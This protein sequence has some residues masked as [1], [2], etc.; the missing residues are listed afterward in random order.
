[1][2]LFLA[3]ELSDEVR[4]CFVQ[5]QKILAPADP[6]FRVA[7]TRPENLHVTV[8]FLGEVPDDEVMKVCGALEGV[9]RGERFEVP[10]VGPL[11]LP[12]RGPVRIVAAALERHPELL[13]LYAR[14][15]DA[16]ASGGFR[17][18]GRA[19]TP[20]VTLG[21]ARDPLPGGFRRELEEKAGV[22]PEV[23]SVVVEGVTLVRSELMR[24]GAK[25]TTV[26][27]FI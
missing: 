27:L 10:V 16:M 11:A 2:R 5:W 20:H 14:V 3:I 18:E 17:M 22:L 21:R 24:E 1:M 19:Y 25:Y 23:P 15:E 12:H 8:K 4:Q 13:R 9:G 7:V 26:S 6:R